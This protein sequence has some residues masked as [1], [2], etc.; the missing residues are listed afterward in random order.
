MK[1]QMDSPEIGPFAFLFTYDKK[2][3]RWPDYWMKIMRD[4]KL[5]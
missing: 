5:L 3:N 2:V 4:R 1:K